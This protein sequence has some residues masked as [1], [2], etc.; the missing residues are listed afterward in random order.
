MMIWQPF[1]YVLTYAS[2]FIKIIEILFMFSCLLDF[3]L[4][5]Y[6]IAIVVNIVYLDHIW[7]LDYLD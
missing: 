3:R 7:M 1:Y 5:I 2:S 4:F 6:E